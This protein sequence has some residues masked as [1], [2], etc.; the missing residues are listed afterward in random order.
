MVYEFV[1]SLMVI[2]LLT[3]EVTL[4]FV[5][6]LV[7]GFFTWRLV[8]KKWIDKIF[9]SLVYQ[10]NPL[11]RGLHKRVTRSVEERGNKLVKP[12]AYLAL[13]LCMAGIL[14]T[15]WS[16]VFVMNDSHIAKRSLLEGLPWMFLYIG[17]IFLGFGIS[18]SV[19]SSLFFIGEAKKEKIYNRSLE[20]YLLTKY[21]EKILYIALGI[22][23]IVGVA[24]LWF[25]LME[26]LS[27]IFHYFESESASFVDLKV[28]YEETLKILKELLINFRNQFQIWCI[29]AF[30]ISL[31]SFA[32]PYMWFK[33][34]R[35]TTIFLA[36]FSSGTAFSYG[37]SFLMKRFLTSEIALVFIAVWIFSALIT[38]VVSHLINTISLNQ[39]CICKHCEAENGIHSKYCCACGRKLIPL[40]LE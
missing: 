28:N 12:I 33:G 19:V 20:I 14:K 11:V 6:I 17:L 21:L 23:L 35:F 30:L 39:I 22:A 26:K 10:R 24:H 37:V 2:L 1:V 40:S 16:Y 38:Y 34:R 9:A 27:P 25:F 18:A 5:L 31:A 32:V 3:A 7:L 4:P 29:A 13:A 15:L 36:L 8:Q